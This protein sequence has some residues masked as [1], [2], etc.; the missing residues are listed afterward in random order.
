V[1]D[2]ELPVRRTKTVVAGAHTFAMRGH[3]VLVDG[4]PVV[5]T[6]RQAA[7]LAAL[8]DSGGRV[9]S[10]PELLALAWRDE[11]PDEHAVEMT[12]G[13]LRNALGPAA[14]AIETV[15]KRG[16]RLAAAPAAE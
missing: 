12:I 15:V 11:P 14:S 10:R 9:L 6:T 3:D 5:L 1:P 13:R 16:Y 4:A 7:V 8:I 2:E